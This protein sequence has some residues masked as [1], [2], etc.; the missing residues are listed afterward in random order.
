MT[1]HNL[2]AELLTSVWPDGGLAREKEHVESY[3]V[4]VCDVLDTENR[5]PDDW[6]TWQ[7][8]AAVG[9]IGGHLYHFA[10]T[11]IE[12]ATLPV[13]ERAEEWRGNARSITRQQLEFA[14]EH[15]RQSAVPGG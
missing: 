10:L 15:V 13:E 2:R 4:Q 6:E 5:G 8:L 14:I 9:A 3:L 1:M 11:C 12:L 7:I